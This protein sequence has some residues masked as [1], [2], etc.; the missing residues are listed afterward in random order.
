MST[1]GLFQIVSMGRTLYGKKP[2]LVVQDAARLFSIPEPQA[3]RLLLK[4]WVIK[5]Q[6]ASAQALKYRAGLHNIGLRVKVYPAGRFDNLQL[7][8]RIQVAQRRSA[9]GSKSDRSEGRG[10]HAPVIEDKSRNPAV[11][12]QQSRAR[13]QPAVSSKGAALRAVRPFN[14]SGGMK[15]LF[16]DDKTFS[17]A[18]ISAAGEVI[19]GLIPAVVLPGIFIL[20]LG[21]C[22][23]GTGYALWQIPLAVWQGGLNGVV[24]ALSLVATAFCIVVLLLVSPYF[25]PLRDLQSK[26]GV[27]ALS[28]SEGRELL[29]LL[30]LLSTSLGLPKVQRVWIGP[31]ARVFSGPSFSQ[32]VSQVLPLH[33]GLAGVVALPG[34]EALALVARALGLYCGRVNGFLAWLV[35]GGGSRLESM[36]WALE[37]ER[38]AVCNSGRPSGLQK[39]VHRLLVICGHFL[40][41]LIERLDNLHRA[42]TSRA[43]RYLEARADL[44]A[45]GVIGSEAFAKFAQRWHRLVHADLLV[46]EINRDALLLGQCLENIPAAV[47]WTL[48]KLDRETCKAIELAMAQTSDP[49]DSGQ[50]ADDT[51]ISAISQQRLPAQITRAFSLRDF[52]CDL[53]GLA[54]AVSLASAGPDCQVVPNRQLLSSNSGVQEAVDVLNVYFNR[55]PPHTLLPLERPAA[56]QVKGMD[57]QATIDWL[58]GKLI[59]LRGLRKQRQGLLGCL[60]AMQLGAALI[61]A[62]VQ[63]SPQN[64]SLESTSLTAAQEMAAVKRSELEETERQ[65]QKVY[66]IFYQ[67]LCLAIALMPSKA[68]QSAQSHLR[69][70]SAYEPLAPHLEQLASYS[71]SLALLARHL[72]P[73]MVERELVKKYLALSAR[74][75][76]ALQVIVGSSET[77]KAQDLHSI[78]DIKA[79]SDLP[80][81]HREMRAALQA[82]ESRCR[83]A[84]S[85]IMQGYRVQLGTLLVPCLEQEQQLGVKPLRLLRTV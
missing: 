52:F 3:R 35:L 17:P 37:N 65:L 16:R 15:H 34:R 82:M 59:E 68:Q 76:N 13:R 75:L 9:Q 31:D 60:V 44:Y 6:L 29:R 8:A 27:R 56:E 48:E 19:L 38:S 24:V 54:R 72:T 26:P 55:L 50:A 22:A 5:D 11:H 41:P 77:L 43:A 84:N 81:H 63:I 49:W 78:L 21:F 12:G 57:L 66:A 64:Y 80:R 85:V 70:L 73:E 23:Y 47:Q 18:G 39:P 1:E 46:A 61:R 10:T 62:K 51:R 83:Y 67:R 71:K 74:T 53:D 36:Q 28:R 40:L 2:E 30:E 14:A 7:I 33:L 69:Q 58:R 4:G 45:A 25:R 32:V 79:K 42:L 20:L